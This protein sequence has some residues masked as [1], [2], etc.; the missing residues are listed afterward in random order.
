MF[1]VFVSKGFSGF[2][3]DVN[4]EKKYLRVVN[5]SQNSLVPWDQEPLLGEVVSVF[6]RV[7]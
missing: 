1:L 4:R 7:F 3:G 6:F 2:L 5:I